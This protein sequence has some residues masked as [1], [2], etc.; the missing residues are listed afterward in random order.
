MKIRHLAHTEINFEH[1]DRC[2][3]NAANSL[4][5]AESWFL[6]L[7]SPK[8]EALVSENYEYVM[9]LP[10]KRK[11]G[12]PFLVQPP[13]TQQ[14]GV[15]SSHKIE[16][17]I[18]TQFIQKIPYH[19]YHLNFNEQNPCNKGVQ[20]PNFVLNLFRDYNTIAATYSTNTKRNVKKAQQTEMYVSKNVDIEQ[21][22]SFY[23]SAVD[24]NAK[25]NESLTTNLVKS[26]FIKEKLYTYGAFTAE[27]ELISILCLLRSKKRLVYLLAASNKK[28]KDLAAMYLIVNQVI[29]DFEGS[30]CILDFEG[31]KVEGIAR[32]YQG[33]GAEAT[34][35]HQIRKNSVI[36]FMSLIK[37]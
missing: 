31:S 11:Y 24:S 2:I 37:K 13:L 15:F 25:P 32:F 17:D 7:V 16:E 33:F 6:N 5:Y 28:G 27:N 10:V 30:D 23:F 20:H 35:Y 22:L 26:G 18:V 1:W 9:P 4:V 29:Q 36:Q 19:S 8:W 14:L 12:I 34:Y 21:F 3:Q